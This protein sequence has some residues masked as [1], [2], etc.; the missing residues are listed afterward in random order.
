VTLV[1]QGGEILV[2]FRR[3]NLK[4]RDNLVVLNM[5]GRI[6]LKWVLKKENEW[7][8]T[9]LI[10]LRTGRRDVFLWDDNKTQG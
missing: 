2:V 1:G 5:D 6:K 9:G 10:W 3:G 7:T 8:L 4:E